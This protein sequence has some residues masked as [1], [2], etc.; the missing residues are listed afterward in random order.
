MDISVN[1]NTFLTDLIRNIRFAEIKAGIDGIRI[2]VGHFPERVFD[3]CRCVH[4]NTEFKEQDMESFMTAEKFI[5]SFCSHM[6]AIVLD[7]CII[8]SEVH[9]HGFAADRAVRYQF[10][11]NTH[12]L[13]LFKH[14]LDCFFVVISLLVAGYTALPQTVVALS[15]E[16]PVFIKTSILEL[17]IHIGG[18]DEIIF[19]FH[20]IEKQSVSTVIDV[21]VS[22]D[23][24]V[25]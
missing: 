8:S 4:T 24:D 11:W 21:H 25:T 12:I 19:I 15:V 14:R 6:P 5:I 9:V 1:T 3:N 10:G 23:V 22:I 20:Q 16:E 13:L 2:C 7:E 18:D 17:M